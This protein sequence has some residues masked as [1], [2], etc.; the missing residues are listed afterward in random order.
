MNPQLHVFEDFHIRGASAPEWKQQY[1]QISPG[2]MRSAL[3]EWSARHVHVYR[4]WM[5]ERVVQQGEL[6]RGQICF[7]ALGKEV[8]GQVRVQGREFGAGD[9]LILHGGG[10]FEFQRPA[11]LEMLTVTFDAETF[12]EFL[13]ASGSSPRILRA[14]NDVS[15]RPSTAALDEFRCRIRAQLC[16]DR[17]VEAREL[18]HAV[19][20]MLAQASPAPKQRASSRAA[21]QVVRESHRLA[22]SAHREQPLGIAELCSRFNTSRRTLQNSFHQVAQTAPQAYLR[23]VRLNE[24]RYQLLATPKQ[25]LSVSSAA[26]D[27]GFDH[28]GHFTGQY[29]KLFGESPSSTPRPAARPDPR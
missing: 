13:N 8:A 6:P 27:A 1:L 11:G 7:A 16:A 22:T 3:A 9:L 23:N 21:A 18:M 28:L 2:L 5:S 4:K 12:I 14:A 20:R 24:V 29:K 15:I 25:A 26:M 19:R 17:A 10:E